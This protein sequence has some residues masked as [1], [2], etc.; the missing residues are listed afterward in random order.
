[1]HLCSAVSQLSNYDRCQSM[2]WCVILIGDAFQVNQCLV[3]TEI[4]GCHV[5]DWIVGKLGIRISRIL[6]RTYA[7]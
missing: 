2:F 6:Y 3:L 5:S 7:N 4:K 1:M